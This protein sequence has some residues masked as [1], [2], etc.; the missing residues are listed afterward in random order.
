MS[1]AQTTP[2][3]VPENR[4]GTPAAFFVGLGILLL[5]LGGLVLLTRQ[6]RQAGP[7]SAPPLPMAVAEQ[8]YSKRV[9]F[10]DLQMNRVGNFLGQEVTFLFGSVVNDGTRGV[11]EIELTVEFRDQFNQVVL[12]ENRRIL[13]SRTGLL[14]SGQHRE[15]QLGFEH[16]PEAWNR[17]L[18]SLR[19]TGLLLE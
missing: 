7:H 5:L 14:A 19:I 6:T 8:G 9:R 11:R 2:P 4:R 1:D 16:V 3:M 18:P 15:F 13:G 12:R 10:L 17:Q